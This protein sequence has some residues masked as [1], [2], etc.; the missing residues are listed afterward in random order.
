[1]VQS[2]ACALNNR[3]FTSPSQSPL[4]DALMIALNNLPRKPREQIYAF[5]GMAE[6]IKH[7]RAQAL[8]FEAVTQW[9]VGQYPDRSV[10]AA[11]IGSSNGAMIHLAAAMGVP[12]LPQTFLCPVRALGNDPD[13]PQLA[14][15]KGLDTVAR[16]LDADPRIAVHHMHDPNQDRLMLEQM[17]YFRLKFQRLPLAYREYLLRILPCGATLYVNRCNRQWPVT[18]TGSRSVFQFGATGGATEDEYF[19]GSPRVAE[20]LSRYGIE[21]P[22]WDPP[23]ATEYA[24][25]AEWGFDPALL[26]DLQE[27]AR[28]RQWRLVE[29][30]YGDPEA[31]SIPVAEIFRQWYAE[32]GVEARRLMVDSFLLGDPHTTMAIRAIPLWL[33]FGVEPSAQLLERY[34]SGYCGFDEVDLMLFS[35]GTEGVGFAPTER[36]LEALQ[37][38]RGIRRMIGVDAKRFPRDFAT[39]TR[40]AKDLSQLQPRFVQPPPM[41]IDFFETALQRHCNPDGI[42]LQRLDGSGD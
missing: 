6:G 7:S 13:D 11:F 23:R 40:F 14:F 30:S 39:F 8:D 10:P 37:K 18:R 15:D 2:L 22:R 3:P 19:Q 35:H 16:L 24:P 9:V 36:W 26:E 4:V 1:M 5:G 34:L 38:T 12:W 17:T 20:Y 31:L 41:S 42:K 27:L 25:E 29:I 33:L 21:R 32:Q 28:Q